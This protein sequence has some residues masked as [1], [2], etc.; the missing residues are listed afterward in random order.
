[1]NLT[2]FFVLFLFQSIVIDSM[3]PTNDKG[4]RKVGSST[5]LNESNPSNVEQSGFF[6]QEHE[7]KAHTSPLWEHFKRIH[8]QEDDGKTYEY[9]QCNYCSFKL[10]QE[11]G[12][13]ITRKLGTHI[14]LKSWAYTYFDIKEDNYA[15]CKIGKND[16]G[17]VCPRFK[18]P[19]TSR[20]SKLEINEQSR[21][22]RMKNEN[23]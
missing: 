17:V 15:Y 2:I 7:S 16:K 5:N 6:P 21:A 9:A 10:K 4:K 18:F 11:P 20:L 23:N 12:Q 13:I 22:E 8:L 3:D 1:M 19:D 14:G